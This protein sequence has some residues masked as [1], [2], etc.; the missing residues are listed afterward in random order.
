DNYKELLEYLNKLYSE[1]LIEKNIF[2]I[3]HDQYIA[4]AS[5]GKY[6]STVWYSPTELFGQEIG[7]EFEG[8]LALEG[9]HGDKLYADVSHPVAFVGQFAITSENPN[10]AASM[11][12]VDYF[13]GDEGS[14]F[15]YMGIEGETYEET[16]D[17]VEYMDFIT[18]DPDG[19]N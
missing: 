5:E 14:K 13:Y 4:N 6:G 15:F 9:P 16:D 8:G 18:D 1:G 12:W 3:E 10:P 2:S 11:R 19:L 7:E 17:G